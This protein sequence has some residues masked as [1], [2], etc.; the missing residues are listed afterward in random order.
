MLKI[1][2]QWYDDL[3]NFYW[4]LEIIAIHFYFDYE[5]ELR[6]TGLFFIYI[7]PLSLVLLLFAMDLTNPGLNVIF[8]VNHQLFFYI[9]DMLD[10]WYVD[11]NALIDRSV[12]LEVN[13]QVF[14]AAYAETWCGH[15]LDRVINPEEPG[16]NF[17]HYED[18]KNNMTISKEWLSKIE[19]RYGISRNH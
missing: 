7:F 14:G 1:I 13:M 12:D 11:P 5:I 3:K 4:N 2:K 19:K 16:K 15:F 8:H 6:Y 17:L 10:Q 9:V 18:F